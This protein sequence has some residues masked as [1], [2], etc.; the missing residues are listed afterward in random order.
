MASAKHGQRTWNDQKTAKSRMCDQKPTRP[1]NEHR[2]NK[3]KQV[4]A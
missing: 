2:R 4:T 1:V 3:R